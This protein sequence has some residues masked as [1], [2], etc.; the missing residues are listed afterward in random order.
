MLQLSNYYCSTEPYVLHGTADLY[1]GRLKNYV[2][3]VG[4]NIPRPQ[5]KIHRNIQLCLSA[6][7]ASASKLQTIIVNKLCIIL[8]ISFNSN[9]DLHS[10]TDYEDLVMTIAF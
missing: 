7:R 6:L 5:I 9:S 2:S 8:L 1:K 3:D 4:H 10:L